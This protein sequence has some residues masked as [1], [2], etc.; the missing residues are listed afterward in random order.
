MVF[1]VNVAET[2]MEN[3]IHRDIQ[4]GKKMRIIIING[5]E[6][7]HNVILNVYE[8]FCIQERLMCKEAD[9]IFESER[10]ILINSKD[11]QKWI[12]KSLFTVHQISKGLEAWQ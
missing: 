3:D 6:G 10:A 5:I 1:A 12:P 4:R 11:G 2:S 8:W 9:V 7:Y